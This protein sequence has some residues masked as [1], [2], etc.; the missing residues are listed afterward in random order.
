MH[1]PGSPGGGGG[2]ASLP[3]STHCWAFSGHLAAGRVPAVFRGQGRLVARDH[4]SS[5]VN[6]SPT[7]K[8]HVDAT[9]MEVTGAAGVGCCR[10]SGQISGHG[11]G[12][13]PHYG[14]SERGTALLQGCQEERGLVGRC[15]PS[16]AGKQ[17][18]ENSCCFKTPP[19]LAT[20]RVSHSRHWQ[21]GGSGLQDQGCSHSSG[22]GVQCDAIS[23]VLEPASIRY[24]PLQSSFLQVGD[25]GRAQHAAG[26][27]A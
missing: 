7:P 16:P 24:C 4:P 13:R 26:R 10:V 9:V 19:P 27:A 1:G 11:D 17:E 8:V 6:A 15:A 18:E 21:R 22:A 20:G 25:S 14:S 2:H 23:R 5:K 12:L 3:A